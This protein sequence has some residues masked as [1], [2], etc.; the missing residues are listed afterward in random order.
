MIPASGG[1]SDAS[2]GSY[3]DGV[4]TRDST[5]S[6]I[7]DAPSAGLD[8]QPDAGPSQDRG[9]A[10]GE[11][12]E[13]PGVDGSISDVARAM[14]G[15]PEILPDAAACKSD[16]S[17][18]P[19]NCKGIPRYAGEVCEGTVVFCRPGPDAYALCPSTM[20]ATCMGFCGPTEQNS[21]RCTCESSYLVRCKRL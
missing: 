21:C 11:S 10:D 1:A 19:D 15:G 5:G 12:R 9:P 6:G 4:P 18:L 3:R 17:G 16:A 8:G 13:A 14:E 2:G 7:S 20:C